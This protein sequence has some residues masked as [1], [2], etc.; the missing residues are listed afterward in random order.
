[1]LPHPLLEPTATVRSRA[2]IFNIFFVSCV[3]ADGANYEH[4]FF[5]HMFQ[6]CFRILCF[7][8]H[9]QRARGDGT[10]PGR[11]QIERAMTMYDFD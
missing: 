3:Q 10:T 6:H 5:N 1:V 4:T 2:R 9:D 11:L 8:D 7:D